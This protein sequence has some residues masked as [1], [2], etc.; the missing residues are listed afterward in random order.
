MPTTIMKEAREGRLT[1][2]IIEIAK[3]EHVDPE[4]LRRLIAAGRVAVLRNVK[5][6]GRVKLGH[7]SW[8]RSCFNR[9]GS[10]HHLLNH[11]TT[12]FDGNFGLAHFDMNFIDA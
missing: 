6:A 7:R 1:D 4:K 8:C 3:T 2:E 12:C 11:I 5:R 9:C 10:S